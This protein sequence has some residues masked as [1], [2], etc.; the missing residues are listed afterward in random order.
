MPWQII[1]HVGL[2]RICDAGTI[3]SISHCNAAIGLIFEVFGV[4]DGAM[5]VDKSILI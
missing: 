2:E 3:K 5:W 1:S 4:G